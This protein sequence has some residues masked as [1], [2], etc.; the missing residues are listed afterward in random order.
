MTEETINEI[1]SHIKAIEEIVSEKHPNAQYAFI[2]QMDGDQED[3]VDV[4]YS[5]SSESINELSDMFEN[6]FELVC[7]ERPSEEGFRKFLNE[8]GI[9]G[10]SGE[11]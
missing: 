8:F 1:R 4:F 10:P 11:A 2:A 9:T 6:I 3:S 5:V 7:A